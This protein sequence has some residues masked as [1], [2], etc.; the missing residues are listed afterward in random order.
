VTPAAGAVGSRVTIAGTN[1]GG[2][3]SVAFGGVQAGFSITSTSELSATV[4]PSAANG[5]VTVT[6]PGGTATSAFVFTVTAPAPPAPLP[7]P[8]SGGGGSGGQAVPSDLRLSISAGASTTTVSGSDDIS[9]TAVDAG[10][11]ST[12]VVLTIDLPAA[13][14]LVGPPSYERGSG[15]TGQS[16]LVCNLDFLQPSA[17]THVLFSVRA[18]S[19]GDQQISASISAREAD[20]NPADNAAGLTIT[21]TAPPAPAVPAQRATP[22]VVRATQ[23]ADRLVGTRGPDTLRGLG[24]GDTILGLAGNDVLDGGSGN[25]TIVGGPGHDLLLGGRGSDVLSARDGQ[26]D[27]IRCG[28]GRDRVIADRLDLVARDCELVVRR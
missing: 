13:L 7:P 11:G 20:A 10:G 17:P 16:V 4:P 8:P 26:R 22:K 23:H 25:D 24:G 27:R 12:H 9:V 15:C 19:P 18:M 1:L 5:T 21:V 2:A 14:E 3:T 28:P 6:T